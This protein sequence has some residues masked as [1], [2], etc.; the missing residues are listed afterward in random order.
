[1]TILKHK[2]LILFLVSVLYFSQ[3]FSQ[4]NQY[5]FNQV[6][7]ENGLSNNSI[8]CIYK[9]SQGF[10]WIGTTDGLNRYDGYNFVIY[11]HNPADLNSIS[12]NFIST[13]VE[14]YSG[15]L[16]IGTQ[17]GGLNKYDPYLDRFSAFYY[18]PENANSLP[19]SFIFHHNSMVIDKDSILWI[20]TDNGLCNYDL[21][22]K[23]F[24]RYSLKPNNYNQDEFKD[25]RVIYEDNNN[26]LWIG[27]NTGLIKY[28]K[29]KGVI[30][31]YTSGKNNPYS[32]SNSII[33][34]ISEDKLRK[35]LWIGTEEGLN[36]FNETT[37]IFTRY[38]NKKEVAGTISD[39]SITL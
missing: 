36:I 24:K 30:K 31:I 26:I 34:A 28:S 3:T 32:L 6:T 20:G 1:M 23:I 35:E 21:K 16:W 2:N 9:D 17:G 8:T 29:N 4:K 27:T 18:D 33:T 37:E 14:D 25:I 15:N 5:I 12:D 13:I 39:N 19:S 22:K 11:K 7:I 10:I 38:L